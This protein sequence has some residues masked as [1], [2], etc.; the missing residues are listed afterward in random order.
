MMSKV[1]DNHESLDALLPKQ[2]SAL[3][4]TGWPSLT[5]EMLMK[6]CLSSGDTDNAHIPKGVGICG[7]SRFRRRLRTGKKKLSKADFRKMKGFYINKHNEPSDR[8]AVRFPDANSRGSCQ[9]TFTSKKITIVPNKEPLS[10]ETEK[11]MDQRK[12]TRL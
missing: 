12:L 11:E 4:L 6:A 1:E 3:Y 5:Q 9:A 10:T 2:Q 7:L 8:E